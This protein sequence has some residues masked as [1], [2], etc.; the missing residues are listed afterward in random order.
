MSS[1][2]TTL[3]N[4]V[5]RQKKYIG[6]LTNDAEFWMYQA[7]NTPITLTNGL[8]LDISYTLCKELFTNLFV[9]KAGRDGPLDNQ[10]T[11]DTM[12]HRFCVENDR[13]HIEAMEFAS[14]SCLELSTQPNNTAYHIE[15]DYCRHNT[16]RLRCDILGYCG[17][18]RCKLDDFMCPRYEYNKIYVPYRTYGACSDAKR[19]DI[20]IVGIILI[21]ILSIKIMLK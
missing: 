9:F 4:S 18:W 21:I 14:C 19:I 15:G 13:I 17:L 5:W 6:S 10:H 7:A 1:C 3:Y 11:W 16:G 8:A 12:C 2:N 20:S